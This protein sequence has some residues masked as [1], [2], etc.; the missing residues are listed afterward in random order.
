MIPTNKS[1]PERLRIEGTR[2][3]RKSNENSS[4]GHENHKSYKNEIN[5]TMK[6]SIHSED[7]FSIKRCRKSTPMEQGNEKQ[8][9]RIVCLETLELI[10]MS[11]FESGK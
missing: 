10:Y 1:E 3:A 4:K 11:P 5:A 7:R 2:C 6:A 8:S 9:E